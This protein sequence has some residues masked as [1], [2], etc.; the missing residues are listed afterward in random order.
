MR[1][2]KEAEEKFLD[3]RGAEVSGDRAGGFLELFRVKN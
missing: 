1:V 2:I 3:R